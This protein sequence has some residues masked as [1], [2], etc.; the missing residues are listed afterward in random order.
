MT[1]LIVVEATQ[2]RKDEKEH[3]L[4]GSKILR[5]PICQREKKK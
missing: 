5:H 1:I 3:C 4:L 2:T